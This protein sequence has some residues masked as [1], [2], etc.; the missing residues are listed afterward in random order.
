[1]SPTKP[2]IYD[3]YTNDP[4]YDWMKKRNSEGNFI[5]WRI[6]WF[7]ISYF[8]TLVRKLSALPNET[9]KTVEIWKNSFLFDTISLSKRISLVFSILLKI[10]HELLDIYEWKIQAP[11]FSEAS[12]SLLSILINICQDKI[13]PQNS[14]SK[15]SQ[16][17]WS[18]NI[19]LCIRHLCSNT[20][21]SY[22]SDKVYW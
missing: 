8:P 17:C 18:L 14:I 15:N 21:L 3:G 11:Y 22:S 16:W 1:M 2:E 19:S 6:R 12:S 20:R 10:E 9:F 7:L 13:L 4:I 5:L